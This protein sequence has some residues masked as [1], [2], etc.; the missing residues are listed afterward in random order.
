M[1]DFP[2]AQIK[3]SLDFGVDK[4][5]AVGSLGRRDGVIYFSYNEA[6]LASG[7]E[8]SPFHLP[9]QAGVKSFDCRLFQGLPGVFDDSLPDGW[10]RL[11]LDR[12][13][14]SQELLPQQLTAL[15]RLSYVGNHGMGALC[16]KP[17]QN[18]RGEIGHINL[19]NLARESAEILAGNAEQ[20]LQDLLALNGSSAGARPK[21]M[22]GV[23]HNRKKLVH[24]IYSLPEAY[25]AWLVKFPNTQE[26]EDAGAIEYVYALMAQL[27]G[28]NMMPVHL[29]QA[30]Q[31]A[32]YFATQRFDRD[33]EKRLHMH[34]AAGLL[35]T[36]F[37][38]PSLDYHDLLTLTELITRDAREV[39]AMY[40]LAV[41]NVLSHNRDDHGK[42]FAFLMD[43]QGRWRLAPAY[44]LTFSFGVRGEQSTM[45]LGEGK[46]PTREHL[47][48]LGEK[49]QLDQKYVND[50]ID[51]VQQ[52]VSHWQPLAKEYGVSRVNINQIKSCIRF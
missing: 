49:A 38:T 42:N 43:E 26:G 51:E 20:V 18:Y 44:D 7:L 2:L 13:L 47:Q 10:G 25:E 19:D 39:K 3:V 31:G 29:F 45:I 50:V 11:L 9:L 40:R 23:D 14:A 37:R 48:Q 46:N 35:N 16:Y 12:M 52:A 27:A 30:E 15:D 1:R 4:P 28:I 24:G 5:I 41:F 34:T 33:Q 22:I 8:I 6:F 17:D 32:G 36:D 21:A